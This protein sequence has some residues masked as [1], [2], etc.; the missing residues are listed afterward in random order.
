MGFFQFHRNIK[1]RMIESFLSITIGEMIFPFMAIYLT[2][3]FGIERVGL[4]LLLNVFIGMIINLLSGYLS[5]SYGRKKLLM[6]SEMFRFLAFFIMMLCN[7]PWFHSAIITFLMMIVNTICTALSGPTNQAMLIDVSKPEERKSIFSIMFWITNLSIAIGSIV[8]GIMFKHHLFELFVALVITSL[9]TFLLI[10][11]FIQESYIPNKKR[12]LSTS[13]IQQILNNY[14]AVFKDKVFIWFVLAGVLVLSMEFHLGNYI[15]IRLAS[16][17]TEQHFMGWTFG[18]I[19]LTG[20]LRTEN[21]ILV[22]VL[23]LFGTRMLSTLKDRQILIYSW[24]IFIAGYSIISYSNNLWLLLS[25]M[26]IA[27]IAEVVRVPVE[28]NYLASLPPENARSSYFAVSG[29]KNN[30]TQLICSITVT[31]SA[32]MSNL[33]TTFF[34]TVSGLCGVIIFIRIAKSLDE[35]LVRKEG[36]EKLE[37]AN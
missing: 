10:T 31:V 16:E 20:M 12:K 13:H 2:A 6:Y 23:A 17:F 11:F 8:G 18:G 28:Q 26:F 4:L 24:L 27:T 21:T 5:D 32:F 1:V 9:I 29:M 36:A 33:A 14:H 34:I 37:A 15:G 30:L 19:E 35:R 22:V 25:A 7:S 3:S